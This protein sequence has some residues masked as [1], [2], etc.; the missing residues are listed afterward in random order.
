MPHQSSAVQPAGKSG[1]YLEK[2]MAGRQR[3]QEEVCGLFRE[4]AYTEPGKV[5]FVIMPFRIFY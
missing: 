3:V 5:Q 4:I 1:G 2:H